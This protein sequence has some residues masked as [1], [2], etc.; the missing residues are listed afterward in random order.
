MDLKKRLE[1]LPSRCGVYLMRD[2]TGEIIYIGK[3]RSLKK[4][5]SSYFH[6]TI[7]NSKTNLLLSLVRN[8]DYL[9][10]SSENEALILENELIKKFMPRYNIEWKDNKSYP[11]LKLTLS[12]DYPKLIITRKLKKDN[13]QYFGPYPDG[14]HLRK[15]LYLI[16]RIFPIRSCKGAKLPKKACLNYYIERCSGPCIGKVSKRKY[17]KMI[18][19]IILFLKGKKK[20]LL[21]NLTCQMQKAS[22]ALNFEEAKRIKKEI[23]EITKI[24][25]KV[26]I[27]QIQGDEIWTKIKRGNLLLDLKKTLGM[28]EI[29]FRIEAFDISNIGGK[30]AVGSMVVFENGEPK[31]DEY[32]RFKIK[33]VSKIDDVSMLKEVVKRR[34]K[35]LKFQEK[36]F[37]DLILI[38]GGRGQVNCSKKVLD[39][40]SLENIP[41]IGLAKKKEHIFLPNKIHPLILSQSSSI[42][43]LLQNIRDEAHRFAISY[44][45]AL[46]RKTVN[47]DNS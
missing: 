6:K 41:L 9:I 17:S 1:K 18:K 44:H 25:Q 40:I 22:S 37:P 29:P 21:R 27:R 46:R 10:T 47:P 8:I 28:K 23:E 4:R 26:T 12:E 39:G 35:R 14:V 45:R 2:K 11:Y 42:L 15:N 19:E 13:C 5:V 43:H 30:E 33:T 16:K 34:Y 38:D 3:A 7:L 24:T 31:K 20:Q 36:R 32:R